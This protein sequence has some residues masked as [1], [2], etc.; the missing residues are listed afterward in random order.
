MLHRAILQKSLVLNFFLCFSSTLIICNQGVDIIEEKMERG[1]PK[2]LNDTKNSQCKTFTML[3][4]FTE[5]I[6]YK[7]KA[8]S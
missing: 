3:Q 2:L 4:V 7:A 6:T 5:S 8:Y 1:D